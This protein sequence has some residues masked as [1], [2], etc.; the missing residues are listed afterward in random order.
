M[1]SHC[2]CGEWSRF[3]H[4]LPGTLGLE[5]LTECQAQCFKLVF[6]EHL[7]PETHDQVSECT[8]GSSSITKTL[9]TSQR[10]IS[11]PKIAMWDANTC[12]STCNAQ[13]RRGLDNS[14]HQTRMLCY[15]A[16]FKCKVEVRTGVSCVSVEHRTGSSEAQMVPRFATDIPCSF[17][18]T[19]AA[20]RSREVKRWH[21]TAWKSL[22]RF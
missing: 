18:C 8:K 4:C 21:R 12:K 14:L 7:P 11:L 13:S 10:I 16:I 15:R 5:T 22:L 2:A 20:F 9:V 17:V 19:G 3:L 6:R 1:P